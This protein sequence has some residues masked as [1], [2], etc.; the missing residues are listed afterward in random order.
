MASKVDPHPKASNLKT[1]AKGGFEPYATTCHTDYKAYHHSG[2]RTRNQIIWV[3]LHDTEGG[4]AKGVAMYFSTSQSGG[5]VQVVVDDNTC[6]RVLSDLQI[7]WG[8]PGANEQ[9][10]H[11]E[12]CG[13][14][15]WRNYMWR[16][17]HRRTL[18]RAAYKVALH[19]K[20]FKIPVQFVDAAGLKQKKHGITTH[21]ECTKAFGGTHTD[22]GPGFPRTYFM[23]LVRMYYYRTK[24]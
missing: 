5:S 1:Q 13:F 15:S 7:P 24:V 19:C 9:G 8:A 21:A 16:Q 2:T 6:Y 22:P 20:R 10:W 18:H 17:T 12:M 23:S 4:S 11:I 3:V 14:A